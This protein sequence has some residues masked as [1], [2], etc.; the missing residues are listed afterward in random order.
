MTVT[1]IIVE[2]AFNDY[3]RKGLHPDDQTEV[4]SREF[5]S[6]NG[7]VTE[8][9]KWLDGIPRQLDKPEVFKAVRLVMHEA[10]TIANSLQ[11][12]KVTGIEIA[13]AFQHHIHKLQASAK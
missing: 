4:R 3:I 11:I 7:V 6:V 9:W 13:E 5:W 10:Q 8:L 2:D 1:R 12:A